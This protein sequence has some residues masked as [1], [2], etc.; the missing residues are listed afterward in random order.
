M[1]D[2][3]DDDDDDYH[4]RNYDDVSG[5]DDRLE[6]YILSKVKLKSTRLF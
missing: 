3:N 6:K 1:H 4:G 5:D 2:D